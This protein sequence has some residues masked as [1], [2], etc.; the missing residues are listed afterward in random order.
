M[1]SPRSKF[2]C[3]A[4]DKSIFIIGGKKGKERVSDVEVWNNG[5]WQSTC[6]LRKKRSGFG[7]VSYENF[8]YIIGGNDGENILNS[9]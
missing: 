2:G 4:V 5:G 8:I 6:A 9:V 1:K 7:I 3:A